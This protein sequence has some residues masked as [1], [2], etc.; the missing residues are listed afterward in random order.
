MK[1]LQSNKVLIIGYGNFGKLAADYFD[2]KNIFAICDINPKLKTL[3]LDLKISNC[4]GIDILQSIL[5]SDTLIP[6]WIIPT[7]PSHLALDLL[8]INENRTVSFCNIPKEILFL[9]KLSF[10]AYN[11][12]A[13]IS[14][15][16]SL[17]SS[18]CIEKRSFC[19]INKYE[20][21]D[22]NISLAKVKIK[23]WNIKIIYSYNLAPGI[24]GILYSDLI[25]LKKTFINSSGYYIII[26]ACRCHAVVHA[27]KIQ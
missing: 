27:L 23:R 26:T 4:N 3:N 6:K 19:T 10:P 1:I 17:C 13:Y 18:N 8:L 20:K 2:E 14:T 9:S 24:G 5:K 21:I 15:S 22:L 7:I 12:G 25:D 16:S 11:N